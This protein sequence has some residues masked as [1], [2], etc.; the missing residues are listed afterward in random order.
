MV[1]ISH[2][3]Q[4]VIKQCRED[5]R[6]NTDNYALHFHMK[7]LTFKKRN[8][9]KKGCGCTLAEKGTSG[10]FSFHT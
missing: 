5:T 7:K 6:D 8:Q 2:C 4:K 3:T 9:H 1:N 10:V